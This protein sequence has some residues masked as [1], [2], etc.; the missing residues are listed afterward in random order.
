MTVALV[1]LE[2]APGAPPP[3]EITAAT[4]DRWAPDPERAERLRS[5]LREAGC[6]VG[7]L[8]GHSFSITAPDATLEAVVG[9]P[10]DDGWSTSQLPA[11]LADAV[12]AVTTGPEIDFGPVEHPPEGPGGGPFV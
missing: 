12:Q 7:P 11:E 5:H 2:P 1:V 8:V 4:I 3:E 6:E 10:I 9:P